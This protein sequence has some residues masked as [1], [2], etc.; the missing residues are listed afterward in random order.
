M[1]APSPAGLVAPCLERILQSASARRYAKLR[2]DASAL[3]DRLPLLLQLNQDVQPEPRRSQTEPQGSA[4]EVPPPVEEGASDPPISQPTSQPG[5]PDAPAPTPIRT[6]APAAS[7]PASPTARA[8]AASPRPAGALVESAA[9]ELMLFLRDAVE[10]QRPAVL[11]AVLDCLQKLVAFRL[12]QGSVS[13][14]A[15]WKETSLDEA[16]AAS[17]KEPPRPDF[18]ALPPASQAVELMCACEVSGDEAAELRALRAL[19]SAATSSTLRLHGRAL[20]LAV[21]SMA[22]VHLSARSEVNAAAARAALTQALN[23]VFQRLEAGESG[24]RAG[25]IA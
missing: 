3:L 20:L 6:S 14:V 7:L 10:T 17:E 12:V 15:S 21:R 23:V 1:S 22:N 2:Q 18:A 16:G 11:E 8:S 19:L 13:T 4:T 9:R 24:A 25:P 5:S